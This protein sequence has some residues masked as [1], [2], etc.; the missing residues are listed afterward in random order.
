[1]NAKESARSRRAGAPF[2]SGRFESAS[3]WRTGAGSSPRLWKASY[4]AVN[5]S[6]S[7][8]VA[9]RALIRDVSVAPDPYVCVGQTTL[10]RLCASAVPI[11]VVVSQVT[12]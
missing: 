9:G 7:S 6:A 3:R 10:P 5:L 11:D 4:E 8:P 12:E 2:E 1:M